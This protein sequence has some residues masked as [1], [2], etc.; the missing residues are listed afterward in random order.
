M[1]E[2][3]ELFAMSSQ[4]LV[5]PEVQTELVPDRLTSCGIHKVIEMGEWSI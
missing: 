1:R 3:Y 2:K 4:F 5:R